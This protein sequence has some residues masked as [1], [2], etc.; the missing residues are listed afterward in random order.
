VTRNLLLFD[1]AEKPCCTDVD[2][3]YTAATL[4]SHRKSM[5]KQEAGSDVDQWIHVLH[6]PLHLGHLFF[7]WKSGPL[8]LRPAEFIVLTV[9]N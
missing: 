3:S 9:T 6:S 5:T 1:R 7:L 4:R 2:L 8:D